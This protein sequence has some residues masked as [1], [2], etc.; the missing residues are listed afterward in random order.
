M[1][2]HDGGEVAVGAINPPLE[3]FMFR[4]AT[5]TRVPSGRLAAGC[6]NNMGFGFEGFRT[7]IS[8]QQAS[9]VWVVRSHSTT[10][11]LGRR[12]ASMLPEG[13]SPVVA[14][15]RPGTVAK[16]GEPGL[17]P[18]LRSQATGLMCAPW[19]LAGMAALGKSMRRPEGMAR[20]G[21]V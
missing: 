4:R 20:S 7:S 15:S 1:A 16:M 19:L 13:G 12:Q 9:R 5:A 21:T 10:G 14:A 18:S 8:A 2:G 11:D 3:V 6:T 17:K